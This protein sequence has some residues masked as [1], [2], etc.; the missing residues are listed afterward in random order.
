MQKIDIQTVS[1][2]LHNV[3]DAKGSTRLFGVR[4]VKATGEVREIKNCRLN[5]KN[6]HRIEYAN[7]QGKSLKY[8]LKYSGVVLLYNED[9]GEYRSIK[10]AHMVAFRPHGRKNWIPIWH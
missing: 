6:G 1:N 2:E 3:A 7:P 4:Y 10:A 8:N 5:V 9:T